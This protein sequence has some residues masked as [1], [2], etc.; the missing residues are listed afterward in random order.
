MET[1]TVGFITPN[2]ERIMMN[3]DEV[4]EFCKELCLR[5]E[6]KDDF[7]KFS[8]NYT[9]FKPYFDFVMIRLGY[10]FVNPLL[11]EHTYLKEVKHS[12]YKIEET[13]LLSLYDSITYQAITEMA[14]GYQ[15]TRYSHLVA[16]S[17]LELHIK[18][19]NITDEYNFMLDPNG[20]SMVTTK[21]EKPGNH[22][23]TSNTIVNQLL[24]SYKNLM[25]YHSRIYSVNY[26]IEK[27][28][29]VRITSLKYDG[30]MIGIKKFLTEAQREYCDLCEEKGGYFLEYDEKSLINNEKEDYRI[31]R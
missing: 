15:N 25:G 29:F 2:N 14:K 13:D 17:D 18:P 7:S 6:Y 21:D 27:F 23:I 1:K 26:L 20:Y 24:I 8:K 28:G 11:E 5:E 4:E 12:F 31:M 16:C 10:V 3:Y 22:E 9:Y 19:V 30:L